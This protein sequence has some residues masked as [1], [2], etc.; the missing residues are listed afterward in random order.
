MFC[1]VL[2]YGFVFVMF[3][4]VSGINMSGTIT[5]CKDCEKRCVGCHSSCEEYNA[6]KKRHDDANEIARQNRSNTIALMHLKQDFAR[7]KK[8]GS[9]R[10]NKY[11]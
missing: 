11:K 3:L 1:Y 6:Q 5:C 10:R 2:F 4:E 9:C 8:T 7:A